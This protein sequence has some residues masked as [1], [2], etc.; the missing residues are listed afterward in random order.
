VEKSCP[1]CLIYIQN[2]NFRI[3]EVWKDLEMKEPTYF[4][5]RID[6]SSQKLIEREEEVDC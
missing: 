6:I 3:L 5:F 4:S 1:K 2:I